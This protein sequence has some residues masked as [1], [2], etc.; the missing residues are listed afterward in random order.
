VAAFG[1]CALTAN[2][3]PITFD[4]TVTANSG[5]LSGTTAS[6]DFTFDSSS[7]VPGGSNLAAGL[8]T[9]LDFTWDGITY[10][11]ATANTGGLTFNASGDLTT[12]LFG[13]NCVADD[14]SVSIHTENWL[15]GGPTFVYAT[16][17]TNFV[18]DDGTASLTQ[19]GAAPEPA[20]LALLGLGLAGLSLSRRKRKS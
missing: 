4:F 14:C 19:R 2:A 6:G 13:D 16:L 3:T 8:F 17:T 9:A 1:L 10:T 20:T 18:F 5:P 7:I 15:V 11:A 12:A